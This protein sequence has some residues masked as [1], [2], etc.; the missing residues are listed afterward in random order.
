MAYGVTIAGAGLCV[1]MTCICRK[2]KYNTVDDLENE[3]VVFLRRISA[4]EKTNSM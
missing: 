4:V 3:W 1:Q 2:H